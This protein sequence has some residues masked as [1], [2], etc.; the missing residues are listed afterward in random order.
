MW[1][2]EVNLGINVQGICCIQRAWNVPK[3]PS[4]SRSS[5]IKSIQEY[6]SIITQEPNYP[7]QY[8]GS[9][10]I[11]IFAEVESIQPPPYQERGSC[12]ESQKD[13]ITAIQELN[14]SMSGLPIETINMAVKQLIKYNFI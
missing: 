3:T 14:S 13:L 5:S 4:L 6:Q 8:T 11:P 9:G 7:R 12:Y 10:N 1:T 2:K